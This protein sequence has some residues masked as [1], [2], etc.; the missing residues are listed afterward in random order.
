MFRRF[1][2]LNVK[3]YDLCVVGAGPAGIAAAIR[4]YD[5]GKK[6]CIVEEGRIGGAD[7]WN[8]ALQSKTLWEMAKFHNS[9]SQS[10]TN[11]TFTPLKDLPNI[12]HE[13]IQKSLL[14][15]AETREHQVLKQLESSQIEI[16]RGFGSF[17]TPN[18]LAVKSKDVDEII[19]ADYFIIAT[20]AQPRKHLTAVADG[21]VIFTSD[22]IM[23]QNFPKSLVIIGAGVIGCEFASIFANFGMTKVN[24][25]EKNS[26]ILPV[27]DEDTSLFVQ[28][29]L[30]KK[31]VSIHRHSEMIEN[32]IENGNFKYKL[33]DLRNGSHE[34]HVVEKALVSIGRV[35]NVSKLNLEAI[36]VEPKNGRIERDA[37]FRVK[38]HKHIYACGDVSTKVALVNVGQLEGRS[39]VEHMFTPYCE[40]QNVA[41]LENLS[42]IMF[43]DQEVAAAGLNEK[44]CQ[45][46]NIAYKMAKYG[47]EFVGRAL[48]MGN[49]N[50]FVKIIVT[51]DKKMQVLG[52]RVIGVH[53]S[54]IVE[55]A[56]VAIG[57]HESIFNLSDLHVA[58]PTVSQGFQ[59]CAKIL[60][61]TCT[62][63][64]NVFPQIVVK[65]WTPPNFER[66]RAYQ[67]SK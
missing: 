42:T 60:M 22:D 24:I 18:S 16:I 11:K 58:Y 28:G 21:K 4:A 6:V 26:H 41:R 35:P 23:L 66:G 55:F 53:A 62:L 40:S 15:V 27:E 33:R 54:S 17:L 1:P 20:G 47:F 2:F 10:F 61:G 45:A 48:T 7:F 12:K 29:L 32:C 36:G 56:S 31:G 9:L 49:T 3:K 13:V 50:G 67:S 64:P 25:I 59:E 44:Q 39:C 57:N 51:N 37:Y 38:P 52:V 43:L 14:G 65:E 8:G 34:T 5:F 19:E 30:E 63:K 46:Q